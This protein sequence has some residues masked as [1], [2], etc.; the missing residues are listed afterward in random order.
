MR[1]TKGSPANDDCSPRIMLLWFEPSL[2]AML[3]EVLTLEGY[4]I[5][6]TQSARRALDRLQRRSHP[7][8]VLMDNF[9]VS[10]EA[11]TLA[12]TVFATPELHERVR[13]VGLAA[14][15]NQHALR[16][17]DDFL[18]LPFTFDRMI[19]VVE[20]ACADLRAARSAP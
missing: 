14:W 20:R 3:H 12:Q 4:R 15:V 16:E 9:Q 13:I 19:E 7:Y 5:T 6:V 10:D 8:V 17:L 1:M 2:L 18:A 11:R